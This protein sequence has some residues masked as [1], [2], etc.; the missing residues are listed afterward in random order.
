VE[1]TIT[2]HTNTTTIMS[3]IPGSIVEI[4]ANIGDKIRQDEVV[5]VIEAMKM[6]NDI[7]APIDC[8]IKEIKVV[9]GQT[10]EIDT[11]LAVIE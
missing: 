2:N 1:T 11:I 7:V 10:V 9:V 4:R 8:V 6:E 3:P 5:F